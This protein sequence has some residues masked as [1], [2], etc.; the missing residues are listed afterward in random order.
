MVDGNKF[1]VV[2]DETV[3]IPVAF[4]ITFR[5]TDV[6]NGWQT[7]SFLNAALNSIALGLSLRPRLAPEILQN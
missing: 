1:F 2:L 6:V 7:S 4:E 5:S 3:K